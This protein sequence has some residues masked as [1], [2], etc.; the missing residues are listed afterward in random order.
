MAQCKATPYEFVQNA[1]SP[2]FA[3]LSSP[4]AEQVCR[5]NNLS[6]IEMV[7]PFCRLTSEVHFRDPLGANVAVK[8]LRVCLQD[9]HSR[10]PQPTLA[11]KFLNESVSNAINDNTTSLT[12]GDQKIDVP[13]STP[14]FEAWRETFLQ[15]QFPADHEFTKHYLGCV[16]VISSAEPSPL[17]A[18]RGIRQQLQSLQAV[19]PGK[20]PKWMATPSPPLICHLIIHDVNE[21]DAAKAEASFTAL[22]AEYGANNC[23]L[24]N[25]NSRP[26]GQ[27]EETSH[28]PDPWSQF[29]SRHSEAPETHEY[30]NSP[31]TPAE[32]SGVTG[33]PNRVS[34]DDTEVGQEAGQEIPEEQSIESGASSPVAVMQH[35]LSPQEDGYLLPGSEN[36]APANM[37][38][39][40]PINTNV[41]AGISSNATP[42]T[43]PL[44]SN[45]LLPHG[46]CLTTPDLDRIRGFIHDMCSHA[47]LPHVEKQIQQLHDQISNKK[48][49]SRSLLGATKRWFGTNKPGAPNSSVPSNAVIYSGDAPELQLRRMG[50]LCFMF[51]HYKFAFEAY[52]SAK[53][54][55]AA[56]GA[57]LYYAGAL[58]MAALSTFMMG[59]GGRKAQEYCEEAILTYLNTCRLQQ[60][61]TRSTLLSTECLKSRAQYT[62]AA[63]QL[64]RMTSEDSDLRSA[65]LLEQAAFC[66]LQASKP[67]MLRKFSFHMV[68]AGHRFNKAGQRKH[69]LRCYQ[70]AYQIYKGKGWNLAE[71]HIHF[72]I[73]RQAAYLRL[74]DMSAQAFGR[75]FNP[76]SKQSPPQQAAFLREY[77]QIYQQ[78]PQEAGVLP[79]LPIPLLKSSSI[80]V[81]MGPLP[82]PVDKQHGPIIFAS[83]LD[84]VDDTP[85][86]ASSWSQLE[87]RLLTEAQGSAQLIFKPIAALFTNHTDNSKKPLAVLGEP[88]SVSVIVQNPTGVPLPLSTVHLL[89]SFKVASDPPNEI[90]VE[91]EITLSKENRGLV[92]TC[93][94]PQLLLEPNSTRQLVL[95][96]IPLKQGELRLLGIAY[97]INYSVHSPDANQPSSNSPPLSVQGKQMFSLEPKRVLRVGKERPTQ[98]NKVVE[99]NRLNVVIVPGAPQLQIKMMGLVSEMLC[100]ELQ[101][102]QI[103]LTNIGTGPIHNLLIGSTTPQLFSIVNLPHLENGP[104]GLPQ[105]QRIPL[106]SPLQPQ[107][108]HTLTMWLR[109]AD[110]PGTVALKM[111]FYFDSGSNS[112]L[113]KYRIVRHF[114][115]LTV[116]ESVQFSAEASRSQA[117][118][119]Q[120]TLNI[121][122]RIKNTNR[123]QDLLLTKISI[124]QVSLA[125]TSWVL[126]AIPVSL[127]QQDTVL[128]SQ[129]SVQFLLRASN[130]TQGEQPTFSDLKL[131]SST[132]EVIEPCA[133]RPYRDFLQRLPHASAKSVDKSN[134]TEAALN[135]CVTLILKWKAAVMD[136]GGAVRSAYGQTHLSLTRLN[137]RVACPPVIQSVIEKGPAVLRVFGPD[138]N[139]PS[140]S[141]VIASKGVISLET[142]QQLVTY[143]LKHPPHLSHDFN[144]QRLCIVDVQLILH[145]CCDSS[146]F[147]KVSLANLP[148]GMPSKS[149]LYLP[150]ASSV[151]RWVGRL[152]SNVEL[153]ARS[154]HTVCL[155]AAIPGPGT[156][157]LGAHLQ[158]FCSLS[159]AS[160]KEAVLQRMRLESA[161]VISEK[162]V[163]GT[164]SNSG[165]H[166]GIAVLASS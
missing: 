62:D 104:K 118:N 16:A 74:T 13:S 136:S 146:L 160:D 137:I 164:I 105:V 51:R 133:N 41:W 72:T 127:S 150:H 59:E 132:S 165:N 55:F 124:L 159:G 89:W 26:P 126:N 4:M 99:D 15:V 77:F 64:L 66:Y 111:L 43:S 76:A 148:S 8:N 128:S 95:S 149:Q 140:E 157:N 5:K 25:I 134:M 120:E 115:P 144:R 52:H 48:S 57:W 139:V 10:P 161:I 112:S 35:P 166:P 152:V 65:L 75:L 94:L 50:D 6:F 119:A 23:F 46:A 73:G 87:E 9:V 61:A 85:D 162:S 125:S 71:D 22:K 153:S 110:T 7:Q 44:G 2:L 90:W 14:W 38:G 34:T 69:S 78:L 97:Q 40:A 107:Q 37:Y 101:Q 122:T 42:V 109:A 114:W 92:E 80:A 100:G 49:V 141:D 18:M 30:D 63:K 60:F 151:V 12:F 82:P 106:Q 88:V 56:D 83:R 58:E 54:D 103:E 19:A 91:N 53:R 84:F 3:V 130:S 28:L 36:G 1:F 29:V 108:Q 11:R 102:V 24:L 117:L 93:I 142:M 98:D 145:N 147:S 96:V 155:R 32:M 81:L 131:S 39:N 135:I 129:E 163:D 70:Q 33:M 21:G 121:N 86:E 47:L 154:A 45:H 116:L 67:P 138:R 68:L 27:H 31:R 79:T 156:Y 20:L 123:V 17:D 113:P 158:V 143:S